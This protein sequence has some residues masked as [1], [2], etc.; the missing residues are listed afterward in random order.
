MEKLSVA[1]KSVLFAFDDDASI[2]GVVSAIAERV[3]YEVRSSTV[4][5]ELL[6]DLP[7]S[8]PQVIILDLQMPDL[9]GIQ[10]LREL[11]E[12]ET[13]AAIILLSGMDERT[14]ASA[15]GYAKARGLNVAATM[16]KPFVPEELQGQ[17]EVLLNVAT[18]LSPDDLQEAIVREELVVHYQ[19]T[20]RRFADGSW[21]VAA[22]EALLRWE[23][24]SRGLIYPDNFVGMAEIGGLGSAMTDYVIRRGVEQLKGWQ[25]S[26]LS[27]GLRINIAAGLIADLDFPDRLEATLREYEIDPSYLTLELTETAMLGHDTDVFDI[28][29]R[30]R[31]K[32]VNLAIDDFG[33]GY[34]SLTQLFAMPFNEMKIDKSLVLRVPESKEASIMVGALVDLAHKLGL[35]VCAEGVETEAA[36]NFLAEIGCDGAQGFLVSHPIP[37]GEVRGVIERWSRRDAGVLKGSSAAIA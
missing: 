13:R 30:L 6:D 35:T 28:M 29:T 21:D 27:L 23:H 36:L 18:E 9:D 8:N 10:V 11:A 31:V 20:I 22:M 14:L 15:E 32:N 34:S 33:I 16:Q 1:D 4:P 37:A 7:E 26:R 24:P 2:L 12:A 5:R 25:A 19:P 17:L 3:G